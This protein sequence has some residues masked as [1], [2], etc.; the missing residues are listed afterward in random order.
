MQFR[1]LGPLDVRTR[2][3]AAVHIGAAKQRRLLAALLLQPNRLVRTERLQAALWRDKPPPSTASLVRT[4]VSRLR[5]RLGLDDN[6]GAPGIAAV[7]GGYRLRV[8]DDE[9]DSLVFER[10]TSDGLRALAGGDRAAAVTRLHRGLA[11]WRGPALEDLTLDDDMAAEVGRLAERR[12]AAEVAWIDA[13]LDLGQH[14]DLTTELRAMVA[15]HPLRER[16]WAQWM[17]ALYRC[18][19]RAEALSA[20]RDLRRRLVREL[21][22]EPDAST[23]RLHQRILAGDPVLDLPTDSDGGPGERS[24]SVRPVVPRQLPPDLATFTGRAAELARLRATLRPGGGTDPVPIVAINGV[25][26]IGKS[27]LAVHTAHQLAD[28]FPDGQLYANLQGATDGRAPLTP[29]AVLNRFLRSLGAGARDIADVD[30]AAARFRAVTAGRRLLVVLDDARD[31]AQVRPVLPA[32]PTCAVLVTSRTM[33]ASLD[34]AFHVRL[35][36]LSADEAAALIGRLADHRRVERD[37]AGTERVARLCGHLPLALRIAG[38]RLAS[39]PHWPARALADRLQDARRRLDELRVDDLAV[40]T[41]FDVSYQLLR[42]SEST[43]DR[44][45]A[46]AFGL[47]GLPDGPDL[48]LPAIARLLDRDAATTEQIMERLV[49]A[50]LVE[51]A[52]GDRYRMHDLLRLFARE[53][54]GD[55]A[56]RTGALTRLLDW[57]TAAAWQAHRLVRPDGRRGPGCDR[58][59]RPVLPMSTMDQALDWLETERSNLVAAVEQAAGTEGVAP[60]IAIEIARALFGFFLMRGYWQDWIRVNRSALAVARRIGDRAAEAGA[61]DDL[62]VCY[63]LHGRHIEALPE[64]RRALRI[65]E[66]IGDRRGQASALNHLGILYYQFHLELDLALDPLRA[67]EAINREVGDVRGLAT[68]LLNLGLLHGRLGR[69]DPAFACLREAL[70]ITERMDDHIGQAVA[71]VNLSEV[72]QLQARY[73][74][75]LDCLRRS[76]VLARRA[77][78]RLNEAESLFN[79]GAIHRRQHRH[80]AALASHHESLALFQ[81]LGER[82][83]EARCL[84][85]IGMSL[86]DLRRH[87]QA[88]AHWQRALDIFSDLGTPAADE[89]KALL[90][91]AEST[92]D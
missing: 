64:I 30:E 90:A 20:F 2:D 73:D 6:G 91:N 19:R 44:S 5:L 80:E 49:D 60:R 47:L 56:A 77:G 33:L 45:A 58:W 31:A 40:R 86:H 61:H 85:Q 69:Y 59:A 63:A 23:Q 9:L 76:L 79:L 88:R 18:G 57:Y 15:E 83:G 14:A 51:S 89:V 67:S 29:F 25:G 38:A 71:L 62:G 42:A 72:H 35:D 12:A 87:P 66:E 81:R 27:A 50:Q 11:L 4:Y 16:L 7:P 92:I 75:A 39:R 26:G 1:V 68:T 55:G 65:C 13:R 78:D 70:E 52:T 24:V 84:H 17:L 28:R 37:P 22:V 48:G 43:V 32:S 53:Q 8:A 74:E 46:D 10:F 82:Y 36:L 41:S 3:G 21:G 34:G 54:T